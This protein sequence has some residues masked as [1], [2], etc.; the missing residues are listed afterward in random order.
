MGKIAF[1]FAGQGAQSVGMGRDLYETSPRV[2][3]LF[4]MAESRKRGILGLMFEG[5]KE[6]L[7]T[8][9]HT[10]PAVFLMG[11]A[12]AMA[13]DDKGIRAEGAAGFSSGEIPA[14]W[15]AGLM[16]EAQAFA[17]VCARAEAMQ[18]C[19]EKEKGA[20]FAVLKL[21]DEAVEKICASFAQAYPVNYN[22]PGQV[23][24]A[25]ADG[26]AGELQA[27]VAEAGGRSMALAVSGAFHSP[28]MDA[29]SVKMSQYL[30][31]VDFGRM[32][33]P[34]YANVTGEVYGDPKGLLARQI[35]HPVLWEKTVTQMIAD[36]F[37]SFVELGPGKTL[38]GL[39]K[40]IDPAVRVANV[41][42]VETLEGVA[43]QIG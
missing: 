24:V 8:T 23:V 16:D 38:S 4:D 41:S 22:S 40:R 2:K 10:Q 9:V 31:S 5:P 17:F 26:D 37:D 14:A 32:G 36:G 7:D 29:A 42:D 19:A 39:I 12:C 15:Y 27:K 3:K 35:N 28:F 30:E 1:V 18:E 6:A 11:L 21:K 20:M 33:I 34:L 25:C 13:L 43:A